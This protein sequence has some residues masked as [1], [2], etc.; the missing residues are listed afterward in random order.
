[1]T[2]EFELKAQRCE[3]MLASPEASTGEAGGDAARDGGDGDG[4]VAPD[5]LVAY[6]K[7][8]AASPVSSPPTPTPAASLPQSVVLM[9]MKAD[10][11]SKDATWG[12]ALVD[13]TV[14]FGQ[15]YPA[16]THVELWMGDQPGDKLEDNHFSTYLG[17]KKGALWTS[18]LSDSKKFYSS[19]AWSAIPIFTVDVERRV[20]AECNLHCGTPYPPAAVLWQYPMSIWPLRAFSGLLDDRINAPAHCAALSARILRN[21]IPEIS[22]PQP[23]H[24]YGPSS[25]YLELSSPERMERALAVQRPVVRSQVEEERDEE[26][27]DILTLHS[28]DEVVAMSAADARQAVQALSVQVLRAGARP[29]GRY[30]IPDQD[31]FRAAQERLARGVTRYT[32]LNRKL[33]G[34]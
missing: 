13:H 14:Q 2:S 10:A 15:P 5:W 22:L 12:E 18:G 24:W 16:V 29:R 31:A 11:T 25:L 9:F 20:R 3:E 30:S 23:S 26:L 1:M 17:A 33:N 19:T 7:E 32:W 28:D 27:A 4:S 21:A 34:R 8:M 6:R